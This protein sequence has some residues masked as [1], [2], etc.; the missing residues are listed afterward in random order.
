MLK[1]KSIAVK[2]IL[3]YTLSG[4]LIFLLVFSFHYHFS[5]KMIE[6][7]LADNAKNLVLSKVNR[8]EAALLALQK[9]PEN[10][11]CFLESGSYTR[12]SLLA[13]LRLLVEK[14][15]DIYGASIAFAPD[16]AD[17]QWRSFAP[18][19]YKLRGRIEFVDLSKASYDYTGWDWYQIPKELNRPSWSEPYFDEGAG[20]I[21]MT[22]YSVPF[23]MD[24]AGTRRFAGILT[25]DMNLE[26]LQEVVSSIKVLQ[27]GYGFLISKNG[28][29]L[30]H[31]IQSLIMNE[32]LFG[33]A[34]AR[35]D[36]Q[37]REIGRKMIRGESG[38]LPF[39][40]IVSAELCWMYYTPI[41]TNGWSLAVLFPQ[42]EYIA[43]IKSLNRIVIVLGIAGLLL[44]SLAV[45]FIARSIARPLRQMAQAANTIATGNLDIDLPTVKSEDEVGKL[46][47][48]FQYMKESLKEYI[49]QLTETTASKERI[50]SELN[51]ARQIQMNI[52]PRIFPA[53]PDRPEFD[54]Y[55]VIE[56]AREVG[57]DFY[58]FFQIDPTHLCFVMADVSGKGIPAS[59]FMAVTKTLIKAVAGE[60]IRPEIFLAKV[61]DELARGNEAS[62][63]LKI[64][65]SLATS[66]APFRSTRVFDSPPCWICCMA[67]ISL[68]MGFARELAV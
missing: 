20:N 15:P 60:E 30:T 3:L 16:G 8:I 35:Q 36:A 21:F 42:Q 18:Y 59:L 29:I 37:L 39:K 19:Y 22:T 47:E 43:D 45:A 56:P 40:D 57:G 54:I 6:R 55:A 27:T 33:V 28:T 48:A 68:P 50:E 46:A 9:I 24:K 66:S 12:E 58:D 7:K 32:T 62:M 5:R 52:L 14:N 53:F 67:A 31:P 41:P 63:P 10:L 25:V 51:I 49:R 23:Y 26:R 17:L 65:P 64:S 44:L 2:L 1:N 4:G 61:N 38:L 13:L 34:E 11:A